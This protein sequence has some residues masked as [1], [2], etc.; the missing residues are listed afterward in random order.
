MEPQPDSKV[1]KSMSTTMQPI[2]PS[3]KCV[4]SVECGLVAVIHWEEKEDFKPAKN[5]SGRKI[6]HPPFP[7]ALISNQVYRSHSMG[8]SFSGIFN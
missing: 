4:H 1:K 6:N 5:N 7:L 2:G 3:L 8:S